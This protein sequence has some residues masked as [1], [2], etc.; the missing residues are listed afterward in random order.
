[1][2]LDEILYGD[3]DTEGDLHSILLNP[4]ISII[5]KWWTFKRL[6]WMQPLN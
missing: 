3:D 2:D 1:V 5:P 6:W 4:V